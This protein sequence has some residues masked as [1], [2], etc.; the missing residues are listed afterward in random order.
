MSKKKISPDFIGF[1]SMQDIHSFSYRFKIS[2]RFLNS[3]NHPEKLVKLLEVKKFDEL[4]EFLCRIN[5]TRKFMTR[6]STM[7]VSVLC[8][9]ISGTGTVCRALFLVLTKRTWI[10][11]TQIWVL[12]SSARPASLKIQGIGL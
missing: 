12:S 8:R 10:T 6:F 7:A 2:R 9:L 5:L 1:Q 3:L 11:T 4:A